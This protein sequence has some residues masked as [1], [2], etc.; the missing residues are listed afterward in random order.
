MAHIRCLPLGEC[1]TQQH[2]VYHVYSNKIVL[3]YVLINLPLKTD[4][5]FSVCAFGKRLF[6]HASNNCIRHSQFE[7]TNLRHFQSWGLEFRV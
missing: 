7:H 1:T 5:N 2:F 6:N 4:N 3:D